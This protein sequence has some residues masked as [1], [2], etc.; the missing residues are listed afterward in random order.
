MTDKELHQQFQEHGQNARKWL[1][2]CALMLPKIAAR[3]IWKKEGFGSIYEYAAKLAGMSRWQVNDALRIMKKVED[4]PALQEVIEKKGLGAVRPVVAIAT[5]ETDSFWAQKAS[6]LSKHT[7]QT[8]V[9]E[10]KLQGKNGPGPTSQ[11]VEFPEKLAKRLEQFK[12]R[13]DYT[14][15]LSKFL[16]SLEESPKPVHTYSRHIPTHIRRH[17]LQKTGNLCAFPGCTKPYKILHHTQRFGLEKV[18]DPNRLV[19]LCKAHERLA[20]LGLIENEEGPPETWK[21]RRKPDQNHPKILVDQLVQ[22]YRWPRAG[23]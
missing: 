11:P 14:G 2:T 3:K 19:P 9:K 4:F 13:A 16:D 6:S 20:H 10:F 7:L 21:I 8:Y 12:K 22:K 17:V 18:H 5:P 23:P 15:L 1:K